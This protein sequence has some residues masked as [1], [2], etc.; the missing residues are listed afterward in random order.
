VKSARFLK[1]GQ[2]IRFAQD[3][4]RTH[5]TGLPKTPPDSPVTTIVLEC[6]AEPRQNL[7]PE[8]RFCDSITTDVAQL[9]EGFS[10]AYLKELFLSSMMQ[11]MS[12]GTSTANRRSMGEVLREQA[13]R[14]L[15][16]MAKKS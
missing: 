14:L 3:E 4:N 10:F 6:D 1:G 15:S 8:L 11:W 16:Q 13:G 9:T 2:T 12:T 5:L 7:D